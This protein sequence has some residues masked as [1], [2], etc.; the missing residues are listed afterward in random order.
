MRILTLALV[1]ATFSCGSGAEPQNN[2]IDIPRDAGVDAKPGVDGI[3]CVV[4][5]PNSTPGF[6][7]YVF[8]CHTDASDNTKDLPWFCTAA[9][10]SLRGDQMRRSPKTM[11]LRNTRTATTISV[12]AP[13]IVASLSLSS[14]LDDESK[15]VDA[16]SESDVDALL[17]CN[18]RQLDAGKLV[19]EESFSCSKLDWTCEWGEGSI[20]LCGD[21]SIGLRCQ[22]VI[23]QGIVRSCGDD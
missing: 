8:D 5:R 13:I 3:C 2:P 20:H 12:L 14:C 9:D 4:S 7:G 17:C 22:T 16:G 15:V 21:C 11:R 10:C 6:L 19:S 18:V 23:G 1:V